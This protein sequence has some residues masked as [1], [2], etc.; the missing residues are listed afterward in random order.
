MRTHCTCICKVK[1]VYNNIFYSFRT[2]SG[3][4]PDVVIIHDSGVHHTTPASAESM[5][6]DLI[7]LPTSPYP[8]WFY[9]TFH[10]PSTHHEDSHP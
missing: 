8:P 3:L 6:G 2:T 10:T 1:I 4:A 5:T 9:N 7:A